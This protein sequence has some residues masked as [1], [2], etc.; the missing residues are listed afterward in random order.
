MKYQCLEDRCLIKPIKKEET[1]VT[2][3]GIHLDMKKKEVAEGL[4][5][6]VGEGYTARETGEFV[7]TVLRKGD[8]VLYGVNQGMDI[9]IPDETGKFQE[10]RLM[11]EGDVIMLIDRIENKVELNGSYSNVVN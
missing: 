4:V 6:S 11:R 10:Y 2:E 1:Q 5:I 7:P 8:I 9:E 3:S